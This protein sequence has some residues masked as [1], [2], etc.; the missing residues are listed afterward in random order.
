ML[1]NML[2]IKLADSDAFLKIKETLERVGIASNKDRRIYQSCHILQKRG[3]YYIV[4]FKE[5]L[6]MDG[7]SVVIPDEDIT[8]KNDIA[9]LLQ[10]WNL[11]TIVDE[12]NHKSDRRNLFRIMTF[13]DASTWCRVSKYKIGNQQIYT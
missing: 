4:H 7:R 1:E 12:E 9:K 11:C 3:N 6:R 8:R 5:L 13:K 10:E 2:E